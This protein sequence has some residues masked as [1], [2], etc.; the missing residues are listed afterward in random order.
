M[1][2][3]ITCSVMNYYSRVA[4]SSQVPVSAIRWPFTSCSKFQKTARGS[5][6][7][8]MHADA[9]AIFTYLYF[10]I[11]KLTENKT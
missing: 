4:M 6:V 11:M 10:A 5:R 2:N 1:P 8:P 9:Q 7:P 3:S